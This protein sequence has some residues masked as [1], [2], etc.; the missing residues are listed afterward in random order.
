[1]YPTALSR[2]ILTTLID[3]SGE[4]AVLDMVLEMSIDNSGLRKIS[5]TLGVSHAVLFEWLDAEP[6]RMSAYRNGLRARADTLVHDSLAEA[7]KP[8]GS[9]FRAEH[10]LK[11]AGKW[12]AETYGESKQKGGGGGVTIVIQ[13]FGEE[14]TGVLIEHDGS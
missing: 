14:P 11:I 3:V 12:D 7:D 1:M 5:E 13:R 6:A 9:K 2:R 10:L 8:E 4:E